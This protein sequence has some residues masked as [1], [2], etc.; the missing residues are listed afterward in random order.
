MV[1]TAEADVV[2]CAV[3]GDNPLR[4]RHKEA[5][6]FEKRLTEVA[7]AGF[8]Q[9]HELVGHFAC[10]T[11]AVRASEP[12]C[13]KSLHFVGAAVAALH[14]R[15]DVGHTRADF[16]GGDLHA[17]TEFGKVLKEGVGPCGTV[18]GSICSVR[19][20]RHGTRVDG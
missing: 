14:G 19:S 8:A 11:G 9:R 16:L 10:H 15:H 12:L 18:A 1:K 13:G 20:G 6:E 4:T 2:R 5:L 17:K 3:A 7:T